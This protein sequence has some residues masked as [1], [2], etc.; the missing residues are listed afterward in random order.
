MNYLINRIEESKI[1]TNNFWNLL[2]INKMN[3]IID[4]I[5]NNKKHNIYFC[6][7]GKSQNMANHI[8]DMLKSLNYKSFS[9][10]PLNLLH[11]DLG[12]ITDENVIFLFSKSGDTKE[13]IDMIPYLKKRNVK[14]IGVFCMDGKLIDYCDDYLILPNGKELDNNFDLVPTTSILYYI[15]FINL[16]VSTIIS[17][18]NLKMD[19]YGENHPYGSIGD[20]VLNKCDN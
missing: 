9:L 15:M 11:G 10:N 5:I 17:K 12:V 19:E 6:G 4:I 16:V 14:I 18:T 7:V 20:K 2:D 1:S 8:A 13:L 3:I